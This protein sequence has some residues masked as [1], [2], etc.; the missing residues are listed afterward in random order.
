MRAA[1]LA[2][3][4]AAFLSIAGC[5]DPAPE[6]TPE[7]ALA[8][9][10]VDITSP[11][12]AGSGLESYLYEIERR[13]VTGYTTTSLVELGQSVC[14][15][16]PT[17]PN[18]L[19]LIDTVM[20]YSTSGDVAAATAIVDAAQTRLCS[21]ATYGSALVAAPPVV[22]APST[23]VVAP[24]PGPRTTF[25]TGVH[26]VG[27]DIQPGRYRSTGGSDCYWARLD[28]QGEIID[29]YL[30]SGPSVF[31]VAES[32]EFVELNRCSWTLSD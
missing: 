24:D 25:G 28:D 23:A 18:R 5:A 32:D 20:A 22:A 4:A 6:P 27:V 16:I 15:Y 9:T 26:E 17:T 8:P 11:P 12:A 3:A 10:A 19:S 14:S 29:N 31:D 2:V 30:G 21:T 13:G 7:A 1:A